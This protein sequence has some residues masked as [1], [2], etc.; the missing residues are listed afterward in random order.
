MASLGPGI[1]LM[2]CA[3]PDF[4]PTEWVRSQVQLDIFVYCQAVSAAIAPLGTSWHAGHCCGSWHQ[5][6][7]TIGCF[8]HLGS[9]HSN[10]WYYES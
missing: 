10:S 7:R 3:G 2:S 6:D 8:L 5:L 1:G 4:S 9:L